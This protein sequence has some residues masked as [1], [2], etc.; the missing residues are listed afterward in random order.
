MSTLDA[1]L[2]AERRGILPP[3]KKPLLDE[4]RKRGLAPTSGIDKPSPTMGE[5]V[6]DVG[7]QSVRGFNRGLNS[8]LSLPGAIV[9]GAVDAVKY[10]VNKATGV[11]VPVSGDMFRWDNA[12]SRTLESPDAK[13]TTTAGRYADQMGQAV[14][15]SAIPTMGMLTKAA[16]PAQQATSTLGQVGQ[17]ML[18][19]YRANPGAAV[20]ADAVSAAGAGFGQQAAEEMGFGAIGQTVGGV[21]GAMAPAVVSTLTQGI[22]QPVR[23][24]IMNQGETGAHSQIA[25]SLDGGIDQLA[26][27]IAVGGTQ[28]ND[29]VQRRT[30]D[31]LGEEMARANGNVQQAEAATLARLQAEF[32]LSPA[33]A[34]TNLRNLASVHE[35]SQLM[36]GEYPAVARAD[37]DTRLARNLNFDDINRTEIASTQGDLDY[38]LNN[39]NARSAK[40][41]G[42]AVV[43]RHE[44]LSP[45]VR[46]TLERAGPQ[47]GNRAADITDA[48]AM[49]DQAR[50]VARQEYRAATAA[51]NPFVNNLQRV[52][53]SWNNQI[54]GRQSEVARK[55]AEATDLFVD[56]IQTT[57]ANG[58]NGP[59]QLRTVSDLRDFINRRTQ[60]NRMIDD[61]Y[62]A[63]PQTGTDD[64]TAVTMWLER[65]KRHVDNA[66][67]SQ[68]PQWRVANQRW[69]DMNLE[70]RA[71]RL[72]DVFAT[73]AGPQYRQQIEEFNRL[74]PEA[75][76]IVRIHWLQKLYDKLDNLPDTASV[77]K[78]FSNDHSRNMV[79]AL[80]GDDAAREFTRAVRDAKVAERTTRSMGDTRTATRIAKKEQMEAESGILGTLKSANTRGVLDW[81]GKSLAQ[82]A[83]ERRNRPM[84]EIL[85]T[86]MS[87]T[88]RVAQRVHELRDTARRTQQLNN[89]PDRAPGA[90]GTIAPEMNIEPAREDAKPRAMPPP[91]GA[92]V[93]RRDA[94]PVPSGRSA[95][96]G[97]PQDTIAKAR[98]AIAKGANPEQV[99]ARLRLMNITPPTDL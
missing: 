69:A 51:Q 50:Q 18:D 80:L 60:L 49:I 82:I 78:L 29:R 65:F 89:P 87:D 25:K 71:T 48:A 11:E 53:D 14:G 46:E 8:L 57:T 56:H 10:G 40:I 68:N 19:A 6:S 26:D 66:V 79:R 52:L 2:E 16:Q 31:V 76:D 15:S 83:Q 59:V 97:N 99:K 55:M 23:R 81:V 41:T 93:P 1:M 3:D 96:S 20:A 61:S 13:P 58:G 73:R 17:R 12:V 24:A 39:G 43:Q 77:S 62:V 95:A 75:Q 72:G 5:I 37:V 70:R 64:P 67:G 92:P 85:T 38:L 22:T 42:D 45:A 90:I 36:L 47:I 27:D 30:F 63:N 86:P 44:N 21:A 35:N 28:F 7:E 94:V 34:R 88:A 91:A 33:Q 84:A 32:Q 4:A 74:A 54:G 98:D 9:G